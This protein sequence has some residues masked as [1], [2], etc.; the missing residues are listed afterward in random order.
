L[1]RLFLCELQQ[2]ERMSTEHQQYSPENQLDVVQF[3]IPSTG[4]W[5]K[6]QDPNCALDIIEA[7]WVGSAQTL[8]IG[9]AAGKKGPGQLGWNPVKRLSGRRKALPS[10]YRSLGLGEL[11]WHQLLSQFSST[12]SIDQLKMCPVV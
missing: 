10:N 4:G 2:Y 7:K 6:G 9:K 5:F 11:T 12:P 3:R 8:Y 1:K